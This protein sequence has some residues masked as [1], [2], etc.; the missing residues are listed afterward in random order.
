MPLGKARMAHR[1]RNAVVGPS[2]TDPQ[3]E[4]VL[5]SY[6]QAVR[7]NL[8]ALRALVFETA[9]EDPRIGAL[10]ETLKWKQPAYLPAKSGIGTTIRMDGLPGGGYALFFHCQT[11]LVNT[12]RDLYPAEFTF[13]G[14]RAIEFSAAVPLPRDAVKHCIAMALTYHLK[15]R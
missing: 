8:L 14:N 11:T 5:E 3:V 7:R 1:S 4:A 6:P 9:S 2:F 15:R 13:Q 10:T 12:F